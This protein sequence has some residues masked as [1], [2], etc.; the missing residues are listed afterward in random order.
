MT[1]PKGSAMKEPPQNSRPDA[2]GVG[3]GAGHEDAVVLYV[4]V[5]VADAV[6]G[7]DEDAV[8]DGV[9]ALDGLPGGI[10][11]FAELGFL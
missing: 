5:L 11:G 8:G 7:S 3:A 6:D 4:A 10:L 1:R 9:G 2:G